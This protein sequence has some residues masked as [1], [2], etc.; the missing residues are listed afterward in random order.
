MCA[1]H[2]T[3]SSFNAVLGEV[4]PA[5]NHHDKLLNHENIDAKSLLKGINISTRFGPLYR[6]QGTHSTFWG[7]GTH[8]VGVI[9]HRPVVFHQLE[10]DG[11]VNDVILIQSQLS[12]Q[13]V[14]VPVDAVLRTGRVC[15]NPAS[16]AFVVTSDYWREC[17]SV[18]PTHGVVLCVW[19]LTQ[20]K[21]N[22][23]NLNYC[24]G[25]PEFISYLPCLPTLLN[26]C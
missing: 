23:E 17:A 24:Y 8:H 2:P 10:E 9:R 15:V 7:N 20:L 4:L 11:Q 3:D 13:H 26:S 1:S 25:T 19:C 16:V 14:S 12:L 21:L 18:E 22:N 6:A 5:T